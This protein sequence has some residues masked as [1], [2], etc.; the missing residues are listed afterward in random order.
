MCS[1]D[2]S[3]NELELDS[4]SD[5]PTCPRKAGRF[6]IFSQFW[7]KGWAFLFKTP[8][9]TRFVKILPACLGRHGSYFLIIFFVDPE[10]CRPG[11][12]GK[13]CKIKQNQQ[14]LFS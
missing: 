5:L 14:M 11:V 10:P 6:Q 8:T 3:I 9:P 12:K 1:H 4:L 7:E 13:S 2:F